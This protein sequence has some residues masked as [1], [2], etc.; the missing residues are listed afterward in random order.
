MSN[1]IFEF[2]DYHYRRDLWHEYR[3]WSHRASEILADRF[4]VMGF[5]FDDGIP[6][7]VEGSD[8]MD[9]RLGA[10]NVTWIIRWHDMQQRDQA[11]D[12]LW[13]DKEWTRHWSRHPDS[14]GYLHM[15]IRFLSQESPELSGG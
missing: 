8:P 15:S 3:A 13:Q 4:D 7:R 1:A 5:W 10:P 11:W 6:T 2:R 12:A 14:D 9:L